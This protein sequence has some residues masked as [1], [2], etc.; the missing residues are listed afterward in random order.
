MKT[1]GILLMGILALCAQLQ[2]AIAAAR[3][4]GECLRGMGRLH[5]TGF[6]DAAGLAWAGGSCMGRAGETDHTGTKPDTSLAPGYPMMG[7]GGP[8][9]TLPSS[10]EALGLQHGEGPPRSVP[11]GQHGQAGRAWW[12]QQDVAMWWEPCLWAPAFSCQPTH[13]AWGP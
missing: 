4:T 11:C 2:P 10:C 6:W 12:Q 5:P 3:G 8:G 1:A 9:H 7:W 13:T